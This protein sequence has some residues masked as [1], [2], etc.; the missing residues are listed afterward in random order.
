MQEGRTGVS[1]E[2]SEVSHAR[3]GWVGPLHVGAVGVQYGWPPA[4]CLLCCLASALALPGDRAP[5][6][7]SGLLDPGAMQ[8]EAQ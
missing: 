3:C 2:N 8:R 6:L 5:Q 4:S 7:G 1:Q